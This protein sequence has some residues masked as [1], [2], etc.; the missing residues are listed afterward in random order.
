[1]W[2]WDGTPVP[3]SRRISPTVPKPL[4]DDVVLVDRLQVLLAG[5]DKRVVAQL[6][7]A[8]DDSLDHLPHAVLDEAGSAVGL[9]YDVSLV[10]PL[11]Q[12]VDLRGHRLLDDL[13]EGP[14]V[15]LDAAL[16]TDTDVERAE[17]ALVV[18]R[19]RDC[20]EDPLD[21][22]DVIAILAEAGVGGRGDQLLR[23]WTRGHPLCG[24]ADQGAR[25]RLGADSAAVE[26]VQLLGLNP[27]DRCGLVLG[28]PRTDGDLRAAGALAL[29]HERGDVL[30]ERLGLERRLAED[31]FADR[32]V[33]DLLK[34]R[35]VRALLAGAQI[36]DALEAC[37]EQLLA[38][39]LAQTYHLLDARHS[40]LR[41]AEADRW[42]AGLD[43]D[44]GG[45]GREAGTHGYRKVKPAAFV[46][47]MHR[48]GEGDRLCA[49]VREDSWL[50]RLTVV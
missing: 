23:A 9:L 8:L 1:M 17:T 48:L 2:A 30:G 10:D 11:H 20:L 38:A 32:L 33:D 39:V 44:G 34:P 49:R 31:D 35:H 28:E 13:D 41:E 29:S 24:D 36:D 21:L 5:R 16:L 43:V 46:V 14:R 3:I 50:V 19:D 15:D 45:G 26:R 12:F 25:P 37:P 6:R 27:G 47:S 18:G 42:A 4:S 22:L 7:V 40:N